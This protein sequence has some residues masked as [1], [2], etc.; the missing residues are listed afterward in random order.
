M[1]TPEAPILIAHRGYAK[2]FPEN[3]LVAL[4][5]AIEAGACCVEFD[6]QFTADG[7]PV[8][9]HDANLKRTTGTNKRIYS[10]L[11]EK[12]ETLL[13]NDAKAHPKKFAGVGIPMLSDAVALL[14]RHPN[15]QAFVEIKEETIEALGI[16]TVVRTLVDVCAPIINHSTLISTDVLTLRC[17]RAMG[18][19]TIGWVIGQYDDDA[20]TIATELAPDCL[21]VNYTKLPDDIEQLWPGPWQWA[22]YEVTQAKVAL[23]LAGLGANY[24]ETMA[25]AELLKNPKLK[26]TACV[27]E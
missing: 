26:S 4:E 11:W 22:L 7:V 15:V 6:V 17:A 9:L 2:R 3:T 23:Q 1:M 20:L 18:F 14:S 12:V 27:V 16:E 25:I 24:I 5:A 10:T 13:V 21:F 8:L 19:N